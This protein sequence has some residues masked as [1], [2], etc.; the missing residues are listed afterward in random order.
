MMIGIYS[1][2][3]AAQRRKHDENGLVQEP[4]VAA[5]EDERHNSEHIKDTVGERHLGHTGLERAMQMRDQSL[6]RAVEA[7]QRSA[8]RAIQRSAPPPTHTY[9]SRSQS[10]YCLQKFHY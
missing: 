5:W 4:P 1:T 7:R 2:L 8:E 3:V 9:K 6:E 10:R